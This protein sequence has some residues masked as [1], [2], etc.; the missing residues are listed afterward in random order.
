MPTRT[1]I[2]QPRTRIWSPY[3]LNML[4]DKP[5]HSFFCSEQA[6]A[7]VFKDHGLAKYDAVPHG[8]LVYGHA[9]LVSKDARTSMS[10][11]DSTGYAV[12]TL[13]PAVSKSISLSVDAV[14]LLPDALRS[15]AFL[16][17]GDNSSSHFGLGFGIGGTSIRNIAGA[18]P[19]IDAVG[20]YQQMYGTALTVGTPQHVGYTIDASG[21]LLFYINGIN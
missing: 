16:F 3:G 17:L 7:T 18:F 12:A 15:G 20:G 11:L 4:R 5:V 9:S 19:G 14:V 21:N 13:H 2:T 10:T 8:N 1:S 6:G